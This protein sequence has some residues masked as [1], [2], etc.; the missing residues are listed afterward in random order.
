MLLS[1][2]T[3]KWDV[4]H[5]PGQTCVFIGRFGIVAFQKEGQ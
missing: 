5:S 3:T 4:L 1:S 2:V